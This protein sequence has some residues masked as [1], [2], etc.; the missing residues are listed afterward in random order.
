MIDDKNKAP[1]FEMPDEVAACSHAKTYYGNQ[2]VPHPTN[3][4]AMIVD[5]AKV[6]GQVLEGK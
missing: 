3:K 6:M 5:H 2:S 1:Y 4:K